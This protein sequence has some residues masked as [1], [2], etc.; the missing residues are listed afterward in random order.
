ME[1]PIRFKDQV[2][3]CVVDDIDDHLFETYNWFILS[4][5]DPRAYRKKKI[6]GKRKTIYLYRELLG[7][8]NEDG[9]RVVDHIN[10]NV[11]DNRRINLRICSKR[12]NLLNQINPMNKVGFR[13]VEFDKKSNKFHARIHVSGKKIFL[14]S[15]EKLDDAKRMR[16]RAEI[17]FYGEFAPVLSRPELRKAA[18]L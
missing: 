1:H 5:K 4:K 10:G 13:G 16:E 2:F 6:N 9:I 17:V 15:F 11:L 8:Q 3:T 14:G 12:E 7:I 18:G